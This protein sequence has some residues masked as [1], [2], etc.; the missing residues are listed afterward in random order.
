MWKSD[1]SQIDLS[2]LPNLEELQLGENNLTEIDLSHNLNLKNVELYDNNLSTID[3]SMLSDLEFLNIES[4]NLKTLDLSANSKLKSLMIEYNL[5]L[6]S[7]TLNSEVQLDELYADYNSISEANFANFR[8]L[9]S[10]RIHNIFIRDSEEFNIN[11]RL[12]LNIGDIE[13]YEY[14]YNNGTLSYENN[15]IRP[16]KWG[17]DDFYF[18]YNN[19]LYELYF[20]VYDNIES[21]KYDIDY[22][23]NYMFVGYDNENE[24]LENMI[25]DSN[26]T[27]VINGRY[28]LSVSGDNLLLSF[29]YN[30]STEE[31]VLL[32]LKL[33]S[34][35]LN[36][37]EVNG[38]EII[39]N[40]EDDIEDIIRKSNNVVV[41]RS[42]DILII[43]DM[44]GN[45]VDRYTI[46][47][48]KDIITTNTDKDITTTLNKFEKNAKTYDDIIKYFI[49]S[50][51]ATLIVLINII[52]KKRK[53]L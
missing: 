18:R 12:G 6:S 36:D 14:E 22:N 48:S 41:E 5:N 9:K 19:H 53:S 49:I 35:N 20:V 16:L 23:N 34:L 38:K 26:M 43:K 52:H 39:I 33:G 31:L 10:V 1:L 28:K 17:N 37:Y 3:V 8:N 29:E 11:S 32:S 50:I 40:D 45:E 4:N 30:N 47:L 24:I 46:K 25:I 27:N 42:N 7:F 15:V 21:N 13:R 2:N 44:N 51:I